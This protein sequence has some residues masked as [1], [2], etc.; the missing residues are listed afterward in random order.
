MGGG[1]FRFYDWCGANDDIH[2]LLTLAQDMSCWEDEIVAAALTAVTVA[3][4]AS[5]NRIAWLEARMA[6]SFRNPANQRRRV[7][8]ACTHGTRRSQSA[9]TRRSRQVAGGKHD[10]GSLRRARNR[11]FAVGE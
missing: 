7:R 3:R 11:Q 8:L 1:L 10:P 6:Y 5:L 2:E 4:S 9:I